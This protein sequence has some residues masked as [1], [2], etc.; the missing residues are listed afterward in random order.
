[1][2]VKY[3]GKTEN[4]LVIFIAKIEIV[5]TFVTLNAANIATIIVTNGATNDVHPKKFSI[6]YQYMDISVPITTLRDHCDRLRQIN[7]DQY[8]AMLGYLAGKPSPFDKVRGD[9]KKYFERTVLEISP[10]DLRLEVLPTYVT[11]ALRLYLGFNEADIIANR[12]PALADL[13]P[14]ADETEA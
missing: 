14:V 13:V 4:I 1:M 8:Y 10:A 2:I 5:I 7:P 12:V 11:Y 6:R 3:L 9:G